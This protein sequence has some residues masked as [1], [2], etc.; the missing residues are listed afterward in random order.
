LVAVAVMVCKRFARFDFTIGL[1]MD[2]LANQ[3]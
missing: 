3:T 1:M 2:G